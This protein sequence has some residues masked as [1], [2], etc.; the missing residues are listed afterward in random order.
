M[1]KLFVEI[2]IAVGLISSPSAVPVQDI[3]LPQAVVQEQKVLETV[4]EPEPAPKPRQTAPPQATKQVTTPQATDP[5]P[6]SDPVV[7]IEE[8][9]V[10]VVNG[11]CGG[12][13]NDKVTEQPT[14]NLCSAG[15]TTSITKEENTYTWKC[16]GAGGGRNSTT[17]STSIITDGMCG[18][19]ANTIV[20]QDYDKEN[21]CSAG[22]YAS[23]QT[24]GNQLQWSCIGEYG[25]KET[26]CFAT[27]VLTQADLTP[28]MEKIAGVCG[29][30]QGTCAS[31]TPTGGGINLTG[32]S[33]IWTCAGSNGGVGANC[34]VPKTA[35]STSSTPV[36][37]PITP[38]CL[39]KSGICVIPT[40]Y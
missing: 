40:Q 2:L 24:I 31:G 23:L 38:L 33:Y 30:K 34:S 32:T 10:P 5:A 18:S 22:S 29:A 19:L 35:T 9:P 20:S 36:Y 17:C 11:Q 6:I 39:N 4:K 12:S 15:E 28:A 26:A 21:L 7:V 1:K 14:E 37:I 25:G 8:N 16:L 13:A 3:P 27:K